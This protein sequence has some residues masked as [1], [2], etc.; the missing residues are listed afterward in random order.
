MSAVQQFPILDPA[1]CVR[2]RNEVHALREEWTA[3]NP[4]A[5]FFTLGAA[6]YL[7]ATPRDRA[8]YVAHLA[9]TNP[10]LQSHFGWLYERLATALTAMTGQPAR[11]PVG[12]AERA[13]PGFHIFL[14]CPAFAQ[15]VASIHIDLQH[16]Q[17]PWEA[18]GEMDFSQR[19]SFTLAIALPG[20][21]AGLKVW[22]VPEADLRT[23]PWAEIHAGLA[24]WETRLHPY[25][26]GQMAVHSGEL[27]HQAM[28]MQEVKPDDER[29][30]LQGHLALRQGAWQIYW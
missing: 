7:D 3:R 27:V 28:L 19:L 23:R 21:G 17:V 9:R 22:Q 1:E 8:R 14:S 25:T 15:P 16:H 20:A 12:T 5:P 18:P 29:I 10:I 2:V 11:Y 26:L 4:Y 6:S 30:T 13:L 24:Q